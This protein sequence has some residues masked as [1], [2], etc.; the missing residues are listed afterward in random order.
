[1]ELNEMKKETLFKLSLILITFIEVLTIDRICSE[2]YV[3]VYT[4]SGLYG[5]FGSQMP[6][7]FMKHLKNEKWYKKY[8]V[9]IAV[10][11]FIPFF[12]LLT[13]PDVT[14]AQGKNLVAQKYNVHM[15][16]VIEP[17][18]N[19]IPVKD[20]LGNF[21][22]ADFMYYYSIEFE[23]SKYVIVNPITGEVVELDQQFYNR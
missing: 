23:D 16:N 7:V 6:V 17:Y 14:Y 18:P 21:S 11:A 15:E 5:M 8:I 22:I 13:K 12:V 4:T 19:I 3:G 20:K 2:L 9:P 1:M 10:I